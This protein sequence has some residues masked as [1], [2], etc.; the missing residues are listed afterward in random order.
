MQ[1][2]CLCLLGY[3]VS[4]VASNMPP[5]LY[6]PFVS[7]FFFQSNYLFEQCEVHFFQIVGLDFGDFV[8]RGRPAVFF[9]FSV[10][11]KH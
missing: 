7:P 1:Y 4:A 5:L 10:M 6:L 3:S 8:E 2:I 11:V 9:F